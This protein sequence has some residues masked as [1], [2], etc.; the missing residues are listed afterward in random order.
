MA[1]RDRPDGRQPVRQFDDHDRMYR[2]AARPG[3]RT[4]GG[5]DQLLLLRALDLTIPHY[6]HAP[7]VTD[8]SG[9]R[10]A[11]R[12]DALSLRALRKSG[13]S[14]ADVIDRYT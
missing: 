9:Q 10:L 8:D 14:P 4:H 2:L 5:C 13:A 3:S 6:A 7:L 11:K 12:H 1:G